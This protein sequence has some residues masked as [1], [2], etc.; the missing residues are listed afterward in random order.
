MKKCYR[1]EVVRSGK[2]WSMRHTQGQ[3]FVYSQAKKLS[4]IEVMARDAI[5]TWLDAPP[6]SFD[7][8]FEFKFDAKVQ[9]D[10]DHA[11]AASESLARAQRDASSASRRAVRTLKKYGLSTRDSGELLGISAARVSQLLSN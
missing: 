8:E 10:L 7:V 6:N 4:D 1:F 11:L 9:R 3:V 5:A 2:W